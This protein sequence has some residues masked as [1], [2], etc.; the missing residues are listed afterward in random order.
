MAA[1]DARRESIAARPLSS[2]Q[3]RLVWLGLAL[4]VAGLAVD[5]VFHDG[6]E[7]PF[8]V[9]D[10]LWAHGLSYLGAVAVIVGGWR[11]ARANAARAGC[12]WVGALTAALGI[13]QAL[14]LALDFI[15]ELA[16]AQE[17]LGPLVYAFSLVPMILAAFVGAWLCRRPAVATAAPTART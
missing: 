7:R 8:G 3:W 14:A 13:V 10:M 16:G 6:E 2:P 5:T 12:R 4:H 17:A 15:T 11:A 1:N 9:F